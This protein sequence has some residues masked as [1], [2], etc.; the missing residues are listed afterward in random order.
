MLN[1]E[2]IVHPR[3]Q[4]LSLTTGHVDEMIHWYRVVLGMNLLHYNQNPT[5]AAGENPGIVAAGSVTMRFITVLRYW[6]YLV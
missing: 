3:L 6:A 5:A 1:T 4:H 2:T